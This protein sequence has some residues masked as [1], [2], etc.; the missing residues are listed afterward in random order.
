MFS[1]AP[2]VAVSEAQPMPS[3][4]PFRL[5]RA[6]LGSG[7]RSLSPRR[8]G[9]RPPLVSEP[10][11]SADSLRSA[12]FAAEPQIV[13]QT[14]ETAL[15][16]R[17]T[18][19]LIWLTAFS[20]VAAA[21]KDSAQQ[22]RLPRFEAAGCPFQR[23]DWAPEVKL[24]CGYLVVPEN[25]ARPGGRTIR[26]AVG[27]LRAREA[28]GHPPL[29]WF[30]STGSALRNSLGRLIEE[31]V[32]PDPILP[33]TRNRDLI[34][35][36]LRGT[37][38][39]E[40]ALCPDFGSGLRPVAAD[41]ASL[42]ARQRRRSEVQLCVNALRAQRIDRAAYNAVESAAD[43]ADLRRVLGYTTWDVYGG[44]Y[45]ARVTLEALRRHRQGIRS[46]VLED[47]VPPGPVLAE[48]PIWAAQAF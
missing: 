3:E 22:R 34:V 16:H 45:G 27:I 18:L 12:A 43:L 33:L 39:S 42:A 47:P 46:A 14:T 1:S 26:L 30:G 13:R 44:S 41:A 10:A 28:S 29:V 35:F 19:C 37:G 8:L 21:P 20:P 23:G 38:L 2:A 11:A 40:P 6:V 9:Y 24:E 4:S 15:L 25:R 7:L 31:R 36:D 48:R 17:F 5:V 32:N